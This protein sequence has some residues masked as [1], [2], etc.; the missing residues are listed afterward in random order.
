MTVMIQIGT[1]TA[2][3]ILDVFPII[4][5]IKTELKEYLED[6]VGLIYLF[7]GDNDILWLKRDF[8]IDLVNVLDVQTIFQIILYDGYLDRAM[9]G[10][11][12]GQR[13]SWYHKYIGHRTNETTS[14]QRKNWEQLAA[15]QPLSYEKVVQLFYPDAE[16]DK[17]AQLADFRPRQDDDGYDQ[18]IKY[19]RDDV[20]MLIRIV[21]VL[22]KNVSVLQFITL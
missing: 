17:D 4:D 14:E 15:Q 5:L 11:P 8:F 20:H 9:Q 18:L 19:A 13:K 1:M 21:A 12:I 3:Y 22:K 7:G 16:I 6:R 10:L 2:D